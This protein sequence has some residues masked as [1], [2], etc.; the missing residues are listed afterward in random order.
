VFAEGHSYKE[1]AQRL[2]ISVSSV[3]KHVV[4]ALRTL[5]NHFNNMKS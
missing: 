4:N 3:N 1:T 5:R 2:D